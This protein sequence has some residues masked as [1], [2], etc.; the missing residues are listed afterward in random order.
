MCGSPPKPKPASEVYAERRKNFG[1]LPSLSMTGDTVDRSGPQ[2][3]NKRVGSERRS[4]FGMMQSVSDAQ[5]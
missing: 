3:N 2:Y 1:P 4:L 5:Q